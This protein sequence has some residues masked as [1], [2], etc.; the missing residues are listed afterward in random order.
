MF[1]DDRIKE[2]CV[3]VGTGDITLN[4]AV[5]TYFPF[6]QAYNNAQ[7]FYTIVDVAAGQVEIGLGTYNTSPNTIT[8]NT[9]YRSTNSNAKVNFTTSSQVVFNDIP[10]E[11]FSVTAGIGLIPIGNSSGTLDSSWAPATGSGSGNVTGPSPST[12]D[13]VAAYLDATGEKIRNTQVIIHSAANDKLETLATLSGW[14]SPTST[15]TVT[16]DFDLHDKYTL[17]FTGNVVLAVTNESI[18]QRVTILRTSNGFT[19]TWFSNITWA[20]GQQQILPPGGWAVTELE[21]TS[22]DTYGNS[23]WQEIDRASSISQGI[24]VA[25]DGSTVTF[26]LDNGTIQQ[27]TLGGNRTLALAGTLTVGR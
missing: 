3:A 11:M 6:S 27:E 13:A 12:T 19:E 2:N 18:G 17:N 24:I 26:N 7:C 25:T 14:G 20:N 5:S 22:I 15:G 1:I 16:L 4:G 9:V 10:K 21:C 23:Y 8:R